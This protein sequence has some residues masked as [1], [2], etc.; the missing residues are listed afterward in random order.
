MV[1]ICNT[2]YPSNSKYETYF[3]LYPYPL[4]DFQKYAIEAVVEGQHVLVTAKTGSGKT[5]P[6]E[7]AIEHFVKQGKKVIYTSPIKALSNQ[8]YAEFSRKYPHISFG[9]LTGDI[10]TNPMADVLIMTTEILMNA[11]FKSSTSEKAVDTSIS[12]RSSTD[13][14]NKLSFQL[15][16]NMDLACVILDEVHYINDIE[17]GQTWEKTILMLPKHIQMIMLSATIDA[18]ERF[19]KWAERGDITKC[20]YLASTDVRI[21]P[22]S[23][24]G[25]LAVGE[26]TFKTLKD[27]TLEKEVRD[28]TQTLIP[29]QNDKGVFSETG[30]KIISKMKKLFN[31]KQIISK[32]KFVLNNLAL[33]LRDKDMVPAIAFVFSRKQV[34]MCASEITVPLLEDD[35]KVGYTIRHECEQIIRKLPNFHEYLELPEYNT[36]VKLLEKG[37]GIHHSGMIP[38][39]R[40]IVEIMISKRYIKLLFATESFAIGLD[41]PIKTAVFTGITKF[42]GVN[43]RLLQSHEYTQMAGRAGRR[44]IDTIGHVVHCNNLFDLPTLSEYT[45]ILKGKPQGLISKFRISYSLILNILKNNTGS[46]ERCMKTDEISNASEGLDTDISHFTQFIQKSMIYDEINT[47]IQNQKQY[48]ID[49]TDVWDKALLRLNNLRTPIDKCRDYL[50]ASEKIKTSV[51]KRRKELEREIQSITS[52][53]KYC[54]EDALDVKKIDVMEEELKNDRKILNYFEHYIDDQVDAIC[55]VLVKQRF[56]EMIE[57]SY[58]SEDVEDADRSN[59]GVGFCLTPLGKI[60]S[61]MAEVQ[62]LI[63]STK[64]QDWKWF[65]HF[66]IEQIVGLLACFTDVKVLDAQ[67]RSLPKSNDMFLQTHTQELLDLCIVYADFETQYGLITGVDYSDLL[68]F[69]M[70]DLVVDWCKCTDEYSCKCFIQTQLAET[71]V[72]IGDFT[73]AILKIST[74]V[75][76]LISAAEIVGEIECLHKLSKIDM[77]ILKYITTAQS[78]YV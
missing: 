45:I 49:H 12:S 53:F 69:N 41:C 57:K 29:L 3:E 70:T 78:L 8:K 55:N 38:I 44:G 15:D 7:F 37:I 1:K 20:V 31:D 61:E 36:L 67:K 52:E 28:A 2:P 13:N 33:F 73:K 32:R 24:Y 25:Y 68:N 16:I 75:N 30:Y 11:L 6:A 26:G 46:N 23:H 21:V 17:R 77:L 72:S 39:L 58:N 71:G 10:K 5:L 50:S 22:L 42:D 9:L 27:K 18:P 62:P 35:S 19:A 54:A 48:I 63:M 40:E 56:I 43:E 60:A 4:S 34:E 76:E 14:T 47:T 66:T 59:A 64:I 74:I 65:R 51:N